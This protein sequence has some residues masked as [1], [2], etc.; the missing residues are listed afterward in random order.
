M[1][2]IPRGIRN[3]N[4]LNIR[5][6]D[7]AWK[8]KVD[9]N[10]AA[11]ESFAGPEWGIRAAVRNLQ[12][13]QEK[14]GLS[15]IEEIIGRW[16]PPTND[17]GEHENDTSAYITS[18]SIWAD[19]EKDE[20]LDLSDYETVLP[21]VRAMCRMENGRPTGDAESFFPPETWEKGLRLAGLSPTKPLTKSRTMKGVVVATSTGALAGTTLLAQMLD[22][23]PEIAALLPTAFE[24]LTAQQFAW[25]M[26]GVAVAGNLYTA[27]ARKD[28]QNQ[29]RL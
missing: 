18:V 9:G 7:L 11:F 14:Y 2:Q 27:W 8:G 29:G 13:Y 23:S 5:K 16:A 4:P 1:S 20:Q 10:D 24:G 25:V 26:I 17:A 6:S 12:T 21:L 28:D 22:L 19:M 3:N 15:T